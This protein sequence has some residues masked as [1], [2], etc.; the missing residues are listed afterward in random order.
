[1]LASAPETIWVALSAASACMAAK[2]L[3]R[4]VGTV[5]VSAPPRREERRNS[6][7]VLK[8]KSWFIKI[9]SIG[10]PACSSPGGLFPGCRARPECRDDPDNRAGYFP[11]W[12]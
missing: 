11:V 8:E 5:Q 6:R 10:T 4:K 1:M 2:V 7:R 3:A 9:R 12:V